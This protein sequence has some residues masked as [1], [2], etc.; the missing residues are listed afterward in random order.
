MRN[1]VKNRRISPGAI[2]E[3]RSLAARAYRSV[4]VFGTASLIAAQYLRVQRQVKRLPNE[5]AE[6]L[7][8][9]Q[10][11]R[12]ARRL[13][14]MAMRLRG[15]LVKSAQ[16]MSAR[17]DLLPEPYI[18]ALSA[19]QDAVPPK[20][21]R[22][23]ATQIECELG[24]PPDELF[25]TFARQP[26][27]SASLAQV[28][29]ATLRDGR[30]VAVKVLYPD[31]EALVR[32][33]L[34]NL[35]LIVNIVGRIWS[36]YDFRAIYREVE[37]LVPIELNLSNEAVNLERIRRELSHRDDVFIP[38]SIPEFSSARVLTMD[39]VDGIKVNDVAA[40]RAAGLD[41]TRIA[42][43]IVDMFGEQVLVHGFFHGDPHPGNIFV[44]PDG[45]VAL[46]D[47]G[48]SLLLPEGPRRGFALMSHSAAARDPAGM[49]RAIQ[50]VGVRLPST[51]M[52]TYMHMARNMLGMAP[53]P[54]GEAE[55]DP[56]SPAA[57]NVR[58]ARGFRGISLDGITG[59]ALFVF[60][61]QGLLRGLRSRLGSP[62]AIITAWSSYGDEV[63]S[64]TAAD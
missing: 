6:K 41:P 52:A 35:G 46:L 21:F 64:E 18:E 4:Y 22:L 25:A 10:H 38:A 33:D 8:E 1:T 3:V 48:Q 31:I 27:A 51:D 39:F 40:L 14:N 63:M 17:P 23:I 5:Q 28:H 11:R 42:R 2:A 53:E 47:F 44:I 20:P 34:R 59:E 36:R 16:Y 13:A 26:V 15:M 61:V 30:K 50:M 43:N 29:A 56:D 54:S 9:Q 32:A 7:W 57:V 24:A 58:M 60:R 19:L 45:R 49:I 62:G 37:R 12:S 55:Q